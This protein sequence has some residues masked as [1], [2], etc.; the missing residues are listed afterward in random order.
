MRRAKF[1][2]VVLV[3]VAGTGITPSRAGNQPPTVEPTSHHKLL[4]KDAGTWDAS[5]KTWTGGPDSEPMVSKGVETNSMIGGLW[6]VT[7]FKGEF[8]GQTF[9]GRG[10]TGYDTNKKKYVGTWVD[11]MT[12]EIMVSEGDHDE[13]TQTTTMTSKGKDHAGKPYES[14]QVSEHKGDD[15]RV[16]TMFMKSADTKD[17]FVK[18]MEI[19]YT[20]RSK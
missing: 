13:K 9:E 6:L 1:A 4:A 8:G 15:T 19:T 2:V 12:T 20:R 10:Q 7:E 14:K 18:A 11:T 17:E 3:I 5:V 16:F